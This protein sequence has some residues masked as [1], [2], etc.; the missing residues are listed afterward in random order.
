MNYTLPRYMKMFQRK[1]L[2]DLNF[3]E[4]RTSGELGGLK[5]RLPK[6]VL[7]FPSGAV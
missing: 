4:V 5:L 3:F 1:G 7:R 2:F 6:P